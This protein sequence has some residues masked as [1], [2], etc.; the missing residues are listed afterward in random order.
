MNTYIHDA[1]GARR[2]AVQTN[3]KLPESIFLSGP[4]G[5]CVEFDLETL[6]TIVARE[7][8]AMIARRAITVRAA[9]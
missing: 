1:E 8:E 9:A 3:A 4:R 2:F 5:F 7:Y 6:H